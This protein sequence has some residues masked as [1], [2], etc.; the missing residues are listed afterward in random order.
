[1][2]TAGWPAW[3]RRHTLLLLCVAAI[4]LAYTDRVNIA[5]ASVAM[6]ALETFREMVCSTASTLTVLRKIC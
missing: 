3:G 4:F 1:M 6:R 2:A 5:V